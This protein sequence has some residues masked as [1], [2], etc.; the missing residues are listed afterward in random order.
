MEHENHPSPVRFNF[1][2]DDL[3]GLWEELKDKVEVLEVLFTTAYGS[4]K[5]TIFDIDGNELGFVQDNF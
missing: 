4:R 1:Y 2:V 3:D 5:F